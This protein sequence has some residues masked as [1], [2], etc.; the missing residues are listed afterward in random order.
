MDYEEFCSRSYAEVL[1]VVIMA[2]RNRADA[3]DAVQEGYTD[4]FRCWDQVAGCESPEAWVKKAAMRRL[5]KIMAS[6]RRQGRLQMEVAV[7]P[8]STPEQT[9]EAYEVLGAL[10]TLPD[11]VR[12]AVVMCRVLGWPQQ[13]IADMCGVPRATIANRILRGCLMLRQ[14]LRM[15]GQVPGDHEPLVAAPGCTH[16]YLAIPGGDPLG[17]ILMRTQR[18]VRAGIEAE[19]AADN[20]PQTDS[21]TLPTAPTAIGPGPQRRGLRPRLLKRRPR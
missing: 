17:A 6:K 7:A 21:G 8:A 19:S 14:A 20:R 3:E 2:S 13:E 1:S 10:A 18:W 12:I 9:T 15:D 4:A 5:W 16:Q 11:K